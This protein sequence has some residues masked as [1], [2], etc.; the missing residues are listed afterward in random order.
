MSAWSKAPTGG[1]KTPALRPVEHDAPTPRARCG[2]DRCFQSWYRC[3]GP[4]G[5]S[6]DGVSAAALKPGTAAADITHTGQIQPAGTACSSRRLHPHA[7]IPRGQTHERRRGTAGTARKRRVRK[8]AST[9]DGTSD[10][11][12]AAGRGAPPAR[13]VGAPGAGQGRVRRARGTARQA[14]AR[15]RQARGRRW[16]SA[17]ASPRPTPAATSTPPSAPGSKRAKRAS[18]SA[19]PSSTAASRSS[20]SGSAISRPPPQPPPLGPPRSSPVDSARTD[21]LEEAVTTLERQVEHMKSQREQI[22]RERDSLVE[23]LRDRGALGSA[24]LA[25]REARL[26]T[27]EQEL[28]RPRAPRQE[29][30]EGAHAEG[31][32]RRRRARRPRCSAPPRWPRTSGA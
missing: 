6:P 23:Q 18:A 11:L 9:R 20:W 26:S 2:S 10:G 25:E 12:A 30:R 3:F 14:R 5:P 27:L 24:E 28:D 8:R 1:R 7:F 29:G 15:A 19:R 13:A 4:R 22:E 32:A 31:A 16:P 21:E 17:R